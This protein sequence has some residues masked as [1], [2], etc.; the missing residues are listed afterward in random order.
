LLLHL[1]VW[2]VGGTR[3][4]AFLIMVCQT[5]WNGKAAS[6]RS[7]PKAAPLWMTSS[8]LQNFNAHS[9]LRSADFAP[10][11]TALYIDRSFGVGLC[12]RRR[13]VMNSVTLALPDTVYRQLERFAQTEGLPLNQ[14]MLNAMIAHA[15]AMYRTY[16]TSETDSLQQRAD[17][18]SLHDRLGTASEEEIDRVLAWRKFVEPEPEL[19]TETVS[20]V[21][22]LIEACKVPA[23]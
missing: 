1:I 12:E 3:R 8:C 6:S 5:E 23:L 20:R 13:I 15:M 21:R 7:T 18:M 19:S 4:L 22:A 16:T 10:L 2:A 9:W 14:Y 17:F 11:A